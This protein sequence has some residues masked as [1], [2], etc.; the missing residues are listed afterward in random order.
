MSIIVFP[1]L[2]FV[3]PNG[4]YSVVS[5]DYDRFAPMF[6]KE[7]ETMRSMM[8]VDVHD[9]GSIP[10]RKQL[11]KSLHRY[12][13]ESDIVEL[14]TGTTRQKHPFIYSIERKKDEPMIRLTVFIDFGYKRFFIGVD[15]HKGH[16]GDDIDK[17]PDDWYYD[18]WRRIHFQ[19]SS[20]KYGNKNPF[21]ASRADNFLLFPNERENCMD[22]SPQHF[23]MECS[24]FIKELEDFN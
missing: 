12:R 17:Y 23:L 22:G 4:Y 16:I 1:D 18:D 11:L 10:T 7:T 21:Q 24:Q 3:L 8:S 5:L 13:P 20:T 14:E 15:F 6:F 19:N 9:A 2:S